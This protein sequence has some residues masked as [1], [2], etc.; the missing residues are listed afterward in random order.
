VETVAHRRKRAGGNGEGSAPSGKTADEERVFD[1]DQ[2]AT[3]DER[4]GIDSH[5]LATIGRSHRRKFGCG[6]PHP[7][8]DATADAL[9]T[10]FGTGEKALVFVRRVATV[11][12]LKDK[13]DLIFNAWLRTK[14]DANLPALREKVADLFA[15]YA[16]ERA[17]ARPS[18]AVDSAPVEDAA[19]IVYGDDEGGT[20][21]FFAWFFRGDGPPGVLSGAAFQKNRLASDS[22]AYSTLFEDDHVAWLLGRPVDVLSELAARLRVSLEH[23]QERLRGRSFARFRARTKRQKGYPRFYVFEAYQIAALEL[24]A[25]LPDELGQRAKNVLA[26]RY[27]VSGPETETPPTQFPGPEAG[28]GVTT[29]ITELVKNQEV[30]AAIWPDDGGADFRARF[31]RRE[32]RRELLSAMCRLGASF[33]DLYLLAIGQLGSFDLAERGGRSAEEHPEMTLARGFAGLLAGQRQEPGFNAFRELSQTAAAFDTLVAVN[34]HQVQSA[35][36]SDLAEIFGRALQHQV[37][38]AG[39]AGGV[40]KR[41]VA[42]FRM[43]GFP[44]VLVTTEVLQEG[45]DLHTFCRRV[46]HYGIAWTPSALEQR[47]GRVDRIGSLLQRT[48]EGRSALPADEDFIQVH[49]PHL[50]DTVEV[51]QVRRVLE[52]LNTFLRLI[53]RVLPEKKR[54]DSQVD[55]SHEIL[56]PATDVAQIREPLQSAFPIHEGW[57]VGETPSIPAGVDIAG[58]ESHLAA[59]W[60]QLVA[61]YGVRDLPT[62]NRRTCSGVFLLKGG[63]VLCAEEAAAVDNPRTQGLRLEL[64]SQPHSDATL[65]HCASWVG[66]LDLDDDVVLDCLYDLHQELGLPKICA[67]FDPRW[68]EYHVSVEGDLLFT[69]DKLPA[70]EIKQ[71][72]LG[73]L[74][75]ADRIEY[76]LLGRDDDINGLKPEEVADAARD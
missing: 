36:L 31:R 55:V 6:L 40:N 37:P 56:R 2:D 68:R 8:L 53:H 71:L 23:L 9:A 24:L 67:R 16:Q 39:M 27:E 52:R 35:A 65:L 74:Q 44:L 51:L 57:L 38:V 34:F 50:L 42:Q 21:T 20:D 47:T 28:L 22:S 70:A 63:R 49:Y 48:L 7:K 4:L 64:R 45:E 46:I 59:V 43:P 75:I 26:E 72:V 61:T 60:S 19:R 29:F 17:G 13:L 32:Q 10:A 18:T 73:I 62:T 66:L 3:A 11:A 14:M 58:L 33:I 76:E 69:P 54:T 25:E 1:G 41:I 12:E 30:R 15:Q 5:A